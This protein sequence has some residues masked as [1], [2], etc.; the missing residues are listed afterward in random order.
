MQGVWGA[1]RPPSGEREGRSPLASSQQCGRNGERE[2]RSPLA[3]SQQC[4]RNGERE[5]GARS[6]LPPQLRYNALRTQVS[7][8]SD[9]E[10]IECRCSRRRWSIWIITTSSY[11]IW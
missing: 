11:R 7:S 4:G 5:G 9:T 10:D 3:S 1:A 2:G 6:H 8:I